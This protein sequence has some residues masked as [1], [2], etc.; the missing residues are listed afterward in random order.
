MSSRHF[1][2]LVLAEAA[3]VT[4]EL[5]PDKLALAERRAAQLIARIQPD[6]L[7]DERR[8]AVTS[9]VRRLITNCISCQVCTFGSVP[10]KTYLPDGDID[11]TA[12]SSDN[13]MKE[14]WANKVRYALECEEK[15]E[16]AEFCV[17]EVQYIQAEVKIIKCLVE[18][19]VVDI[20]FNQVGGL[21]TLCF[22]EEIDCLINN[23]YLFKRSIILI[24]AWCY[25]ESRIL[26][27]HH[28]LISTY[29]LETLVL[30][31]FHIFNNK[32]TGPLEV[33]YRFLEFFSNYDWEHYC[34]SLW[35]PVP[36]SSLPHMI[37]ETPRR[38]DGTLLLNKPFLD[39][40]V[41]RYAVCP[42]GQETP[43]FASKHFN[44]IDPLRTNN[45]LGRSVSK[46]NFFRIR[47]AFAFGARRLAMLLEGQKDNLVA[48][49]NQFFRNTWER[50][51]SGIRPDAPVP[52]LHNLQSPE[53][54][55]V[56]DSRRH[57]S[58]DYNNKKKS[59]SHAVPQMNREKESETIHDF[60]ASNSKLPLASTQKTHVVRPE[61]VEQFEGNYTTSS[62]SGANNRSRDQ[63]TVKPQYSLNSNSGL[64]RFQFVR[65]RSSPE[66][67]DSSVES[68]PRTRR[69]RAVD[70]GKT[71]R[72]ENGLVRRSNANPGSEIT[73]AHSTK[74]SLDDFPR[75]FNS[76]SPHPSLEGGASDT[77]SVSNSYDNGFASI[78]EELSS[79][80]ETE[81][82]QEMSQEEQDM[83]NLMGMQGLNGQ[84]QLPTHMV[85][86]PH[87]PFAF[88]PL[89]ASGAQ[90]HGNWAGVLPANLANLSLI[91]APWSQNL[92][93]PGFV[94]PPLAP[95]SQSPFVSNLDETVSTNR[96]E[97]V[98][99]NHVENMEL[100]HDS[101]GAVV[102]PTEEQNSSWRENSSITRQP[103][104]SRDNAGGSNLVPM[105]HGT[106]AHFVVPAQPRLGRDN[107]GSL[108]EDVSNEPRNQMGRLADVSSS[109]ARVSTTRQSSW[110][111]SQSRGRSLY[112]GSRNRTGERFPRSPKDK[113]ERKSTSFSGPASPYAKGKPVSQPE[114]T[115]ED[116]FSEADNEII[117][118]ASTSA[119]EE[120]GPDRIS[121]MGYDPAVRTN[122]PG[123][124][125]VFP[126]GGPV[127][128]SSPRQRM[129]DNP[130]GAPM[131]FVQTGPPIFYMVPYN[132]PHDMNNNDIVPNHID[133]E[134]ATSQGDRDCDAG[135]NSDVVEA[136][137]R[138][139]PSSTPSPIASVTDSE[140][141]VK[142]DILNSDFNSHLQNLMFGR[143]CQ[144]GPYQGPLVA[145]S[146]I[147]V[148]P[149]LLQTH[150]PSEGARPMSGNVNATPVMGYGPRLIPVMP[151]QSGPER[152]SG[153]AQ[154]FGEEAP[155]SR[156]GTGT[157]LPNP[158][159]YRER[160]SST[161]NQ[162]W[163]NHHNDRT[164]D[165]YDRE[166]S[167]IN[168]KQQRAAAARRASSR[169]DRHHH[170]QPP[171]E[172][173]S[174]GHWQTYRNDSYRQEDQP[175]AAS[176]YAVLENSPLGAAPAAPHRPA[177]MG[178]SMYL[179]PPVSNGA[180]VGPPGPPNPL[181]MVY[182]YDQGGAGYNR[183]A[184]P[185]EF[186]SLR[187]DEVT[188]Q[189]EQR[190]G[191]SSRSTPEPPSS[192][193]SRR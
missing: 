34:L 181:V 162:R 103:T 139:D 14:I 80:A 8:G 51:G 91:N 193:H 68:F 1:N 176:S 77:H 153:V 32:F 6:T 140:D 168:A 101:S 154:R 41:S 82:R 63:K 112:E 109:D 7:S 94:P 83:V 143:F 125:P 16:N 5:E 108:G 100:P 189:P 59:H 18:N 192:P 57:R 185:V 127:L 21:C 49:L 179:A 166:G 175:V 76:S 111:E 35:G 182:S 81:I 48:E 149:M 128:L 119:S 88:S 157:Y 106:N 39:R 174:E 12:L 105:T 160:Q 38:D 151:F 129:M 144:K 86:S 180:A 121:H 53:N 23:D 116:S 117:D 147:M 31:I 33:L 84:F 20:S 65:T 113:W 165:H 152:V 170:H 146:P 44:V 124:N 42:G 107:V 72:S 97:A 150:F 10:L 89:L 78:S 178:Y 135:Y 184:E 52:D 110:K 123:P 29:A 158:V 141:R 70:N 22:L 118:W 172:H 167:W 71:T 36:I 115:P 66:L 75:S 190:P 183:S 3:N 177:N 50:H 69:G 47:S 122:G 187:H 13:D 24:K 4:R 28:G 17:K 163:N 164:T 156:V 26:G 40:C 67:T 15:N 45:N 9:Y 74:S 87:L 90:A 79:A 93:F 25:Y 30:Y 64:A 138:I 61:F 137:V 96:D 55:P 37:A 188:L 102:E 19:I 2:G 171:S 169:A 191:G 95:Y 92:Q 145:Q 142:S 131:T 27:A 148:P 43:P 136:Q 54:V 161:R 173:Q 159:A 46:G 126:I 114:S 98:T 130:G 73:G 85:P 120:S 186:G 62:S 11:L 56:E 134:E 104:K 155:R 132:F 99:S 133:R 58:T 60:R